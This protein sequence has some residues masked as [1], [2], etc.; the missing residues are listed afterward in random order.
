M[1]QPYYQDEQVTLY[2]GDCLE[3]MR[4]MD[5]ASVDAVVTSPPYDNLRTYNGFEWDFEGTARELFRILRDGGVACWNVGDATVDGSET[6]TSLKQA[7]YFKD[8]V[9]FRVHDTMI[10]EKAN[11]AHP[12]QVRYHQIF[13]YVFVLSKDA[14]RCFN[15]IKDKKNVWAGT[16]PFGRNTMR[17][18]D[19][20]LKERERNT[21][22]EYGMRGNVWRC[23]TAGQENICEPIG[24]PAV[25]P[26]GLCR[27]L[28]LSWSDPNCVI[29][30]PFM[31]SG[32]TGLA[33][34]NHNRRF[35][36]IEIDEHY[37]EIAAKR[38]QQAQQQAMLP[39]EVA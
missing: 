15:P 31:G 21:I 3:V 28:V 6:L 23:K 19:G 8:T 30:D 35:I 39:L 37:C 2:H 24:H 16:G 10:Y 34:I 20:S 17:Q 9:G 36:G 4:E 18:K 22:A 11:F 29:L 14:P 38:I 1:I 26:Y 5:A 7:V 13:E 12:E 33:C 32:T 27:D 25:M